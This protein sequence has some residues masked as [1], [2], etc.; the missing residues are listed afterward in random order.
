[1]KSIQLSK[2]LILKKTTITDLSDEKMLRVKGGGPTDDPTCFATYK[3]ACPPRC[4]DFFCE[5]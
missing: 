5:C 3:T 1:M 4:T 2:K